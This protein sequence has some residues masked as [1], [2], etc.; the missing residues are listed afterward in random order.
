VKTLSST[1]PDEITDPTADIYD[2]QLQAPN[3]TSF[4]VSPLQMALAASTLSN[5]GE[6]PAPRLFTAYETPQANWVVLPVTGPAQPVFQE[7]KA[8]N[9]AHALA[10]STLP[11]WQVVAEAD[12]ATGNASGSSSSYSWYL[13]GTLP[14]WKGAP[15]A[16]AILLEEHNPV[17]LQSI[18]QSIFR[19]AI[20]P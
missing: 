3:G 1:K 6:R 18:G 5:A 16:M 19:S 2:Q 7:L 11:V 13:G 9:I 14:E 8:V 10:S 17:L 12:E 20:Y 15:L 4:K